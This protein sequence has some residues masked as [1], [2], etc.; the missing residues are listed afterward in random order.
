MYLSREE[1]IKRVNGYEGFSQIKVMENGISAYDE[2]KEKY[3]HFNFLDNI[4]YDNIFC[5]GSVDIDKENF[6]KIIKEKL[7]PILFLTTKKIFFIS[8]N[9]EVEEVF[10]NI[11]IRERDYNSFMENILGV[12]YLQESVIVINA[13]LIKEMAKECSENE[14]YRFNYKVYLNQLIW[15]TLIDTLKRMTNINGKRICENEQFIEDI[16][17]ERY[18]D[19]VFD[20]DISCESFLVIKD[21]KI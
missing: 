12:S 13:H 16:E 20:D 1:I 8:S 2:K 7:D 4:N 3:I 9:E 11:K 17:N 14:R 19:K 10:K 15:T 5:F 6:Y 21:L 18:A